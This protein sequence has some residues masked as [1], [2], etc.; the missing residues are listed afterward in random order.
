M[1]QHVMTVAIT[2]GAGKDNNA[3]LHKLFLVS[4]RWCVWANS[5]KGEQLLKREEYLLLSLYH[6]AALRGRWQQ[7]SSK[8]TYQAK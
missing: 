2:P 8:M 5:K 6:G 1:R 7:C 4:S 3:K